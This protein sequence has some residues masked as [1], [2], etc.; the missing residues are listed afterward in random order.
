[1]QLRGRVDLEATLAQL[2]AR[3]GSPDM[4]MCMLH[5]HVHVHVHVHLV[6]A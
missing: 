4:C 2:A 5:V 1:M 6:Y 3:R